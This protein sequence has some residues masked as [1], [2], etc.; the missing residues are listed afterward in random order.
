LLW[1]QTFHP[2]V[3][4][5]LNRNLIQFLPRVMEIDR[6]D[7]LGMLERMLAV[8]L[9]DSRGEQH[10]APGRGREVGDDHFA[11]HLQRFLG[12]F[13]VRDAFDFDRCACRQPAFHFLFDLL[14]PPRI[15]LAQRLPSARERLL[16]PE[17]DL[18][19]SFQ[20]SVLV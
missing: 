14:P 17:G 13:P 8:H 19:L 9:E 20:A 10:P 15:V 3:G 7:A 12:A 16:A 11:L 2:V 1:W 5:Q 4:W 6:M 18:Q